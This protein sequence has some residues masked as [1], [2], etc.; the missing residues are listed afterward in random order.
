MASNHSLLRIVARPASEVDATQSLRAGV[1]A[2]GRASTAPNRRQKW[3]PA[4]ARQIDDL[5]DRKEFRRRP[6]GSS[7]VSPAPAR[8]RDFSRLLGRARST[9]FMDLGRQSPRIRPGVTDRHCA[10]RANGS[11]PRPA[12]GQAPR[13]GPEPMNSGLCS[14]VP[15][16]SPG[17]ARNDNALNLLRQPCEY[18]SKPNAGPVRRR[19]RTGP[20]A[21][22]ARGEAN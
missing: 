22:A 21:E 16:S 3:G 20:S 12:R 9:A 6:A 15:G 10:G 18:R 8:N 5:K 13:G 2:G 14:S 19:R 17:G 4:A 7:S 11:G 1:A